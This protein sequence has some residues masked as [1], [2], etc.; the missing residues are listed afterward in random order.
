VND[1]LPELQTLRFGSPWW[2]L[3]LALIPLG[4]WLRGRAAPVAAVQYS[5]GALLHAAARKARF[6]PGQMLPAIR[7]FA[8]TLLILALARPQVD[9]GLSDREALGINIMFCLDFSST[10][11]TK[12]FLID[13]RRVT[14]VDGMKKVVTE[15]INARPN[16]RIGAVAFDAGAHLISPLTLDH[17]WL[18]GQLAA[19][20]PGRGTAP[21]SGMLIAAEALIPVKTQSKVMITVT[22]ADQVNEG[23]LPEEVANALKPMGIRN[24]IIQIVDFSQ[25][26]QTTAS[27]QLFATVARVTGGQFFKVSDVAGLRGVYAQID[28]LEKSAFKESK[29]QSW[30]ELMV[31]LAGPALGLLL[32]EFGLSRTTWRKLP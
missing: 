4:M 3:A 24:H 13:G 7:Y 26:Q 16:D 32:L 28:Q 6:R 2:L 1:F 21:G 30:R 8:L 25:M 22:D 12:D 10:M 27:G 29:Q 9:K 15:F 18:I 11:K 5:S 23:P 31:W 19:E 14:R 20:E 17:E